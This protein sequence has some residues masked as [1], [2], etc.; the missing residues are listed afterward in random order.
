[1]REFLITLLIGV[2]AGGIDVLPM[3]KMKLDKY[4]ISSA[5]V[6]YLIAPFIIFNIKLFSNA[7]WLKGGIIT[8]ALAAP[9]II[10]VAKDDKKSILPMSA[11]SV[12]LG[13]L[14]GIAGYFL[15]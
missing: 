2:I 9:I 12:I 8:L 6:H 11:T 5:F 15:L 13:T 3:I 1:M 10:L 7:W 4:S 14:M